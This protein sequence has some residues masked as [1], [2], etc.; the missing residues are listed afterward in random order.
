MFRN[1]SELH[2]HSM[3]SLS[4][5]NGFPYMSVYLFFKGS[6]A[7]DSITEVLFYFKVYTQHSEWIVEPGDKC[8]LELKNGVFCLLS[9]DSY[10]KGN[11]TLEKQLSNFLHETQFFN[12]Q[13]LNIT[14]LFLWSGGIIGWCF[15]FSFQKYVYIFLFVQTSWTEIFEVSVGTCWKEDK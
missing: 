5:S 14:P 8:Y 1:W 2:G 10:T 12:H 4:H 6:P 7:R 9:S 15:I 3:D 13:L 11:C